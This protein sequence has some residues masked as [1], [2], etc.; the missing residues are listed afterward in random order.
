MPATGSVSS[1]TV[2][3]LCVPVEEIVQD[4]NGFLR[5]WAGYFRYGNSARTST[6]I[7]D[8]RVARLAGSSPSVTN[9]PG[10]DGGFYP[11]ARTGWG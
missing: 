9:A 11:L 8:P 5:G 6:Q 10:M 7:S 1:R 3:R 2:E 4:L